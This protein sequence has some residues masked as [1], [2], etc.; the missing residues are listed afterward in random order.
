MIVSEFKPNLFILGVAKSGTTSI[1]NFLSEIDSICMS[2]PK[3]PIFFE[4]E[5]D[6]GLDFYHQK[7]FAHWNGESLIGESRHRNLYLPYIPKR[8]KS[9]NENPKL[10]VI[11]RNP[12]E[13][14]FS[15]WW[16]FFSRGQ[17]NLGFKDAIMN[18]LKRIE[19]GKCIND[20]ESI[21][22]YCQN[23]NGFLNGI[24]RTYIDS[25]Y[26]FE[27]ISRYLELFPKESL[28]ILSFAELISDEQ[29]VIT[30]L[31]QFLELNP[32]ELP[33]AIAKQNEKRVVST[34]GKLKSVLR[35]TGIGKLIP[36]KYKVAFESRQ[37]E[38][39]RME[40]YDQETVKM[41]K[42]HFRTHNDKLK[43]LIDFNIDSWY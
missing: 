32:E 6:E 1:H 31:A 41:L 28:L 9:I 42:E 25:G 18:D 33:V 17:E 8:I 4:C 24:Y 3:E 2:N 10:I 36:V 14:A 40:Q 7:Y 35:S 38:K 20:D 13:R 16:H 22:K 26:Y 30:K 23:V 37:T 11:L 29:S 21:G 39:L 15:H 5:F 12:V 19:S 43:E 34:K 27:Q